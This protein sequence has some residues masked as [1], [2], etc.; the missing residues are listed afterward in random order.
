[1]WSWASMSPGMMVL[2]RTSTTSA[3]P[4]QDRPWRGPAAAIRSP[5]MTMTAS[6]TGAAPVPSIKVA[7]VRTR[8]IAQPS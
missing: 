2:P 1:M 8:I 3:S 4:G 5:S 7:P 6:A